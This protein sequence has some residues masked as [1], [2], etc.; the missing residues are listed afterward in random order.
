MSVRDVSVMS[1]RES[2]DAVRV[3]CGVRARVDRGRS[4][5]GGG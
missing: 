2:F 1:C 3:P 5:T 4:G